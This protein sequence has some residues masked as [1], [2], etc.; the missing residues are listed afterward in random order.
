MQFEINDVKAFGRKQL[1]RMLQL[2]DLLQRQAAN[3]DEYFVENY[4]Q[5]CQHLA[6]YEQFNLAGNTKDNFVKQKHEEKTYL[7]E[8]DLKLK[9][10][11]VNPLR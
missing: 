4:K 5:V 2:K 11:F 7:H 9:K 8:E 1:D 10:S 6:S 3:K